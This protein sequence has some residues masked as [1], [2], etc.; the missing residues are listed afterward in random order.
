MIDITQDNLPVIGDMITDTEDGS[1]GVVYDIKLK[2]Y[3]V[4]W[5]H[6][7]QPER[8]LDTQENPYSLESFKLIPT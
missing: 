1:I 4:Y 6:L 3:L 8:I 2:T 7:P 5:I